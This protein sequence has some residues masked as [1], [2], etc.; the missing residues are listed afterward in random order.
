MSAYIVSHY[1]INAL[2]SYAVRQEVSFYWKNKRY[3]F[4]RD[5]ANDLAGQLYS[6]N[7][8][9]VNSRYNER[10]RRVG[11][12][13]ERV[14]T[15]HLNHDDI[16]KACD[17]L[18]YQSSETRNY[19]RTLAYAALQAIREEAIDQLVDDCHTWELNQPQPNNLVKAA[20]ALGKIEFAFVT[21]GAA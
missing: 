7:V 8:R 6:E 17:C 20:Q 1:H 3:V 19:E 4:N 13:F 2:T 10:T 11:F 15:D 9:S 18:R 5:S 16:I 12:K 14:L 21:G